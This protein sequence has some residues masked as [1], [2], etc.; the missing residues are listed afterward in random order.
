MSTN[1]SYSP[2]T[3]QPAHWGFLGTVICGA[4]ISVIFV[5]LQILTIIVAVVARK[6][7]FS[8]SEFLLIFNSAARNGYFLAIST[9]ITT[10][11]CVVL[12]AG[13]IKLKKGSVLREYLAIKP[14]P[15][16]AMLKWTGLLVSF[17]I[18][19]DLTTFFLGR[20]IVPEFM[21]AVYAT[22]NPVWMIWFALIIAAPLFEEIFFR[23]FL[24]KGFESSF[25]GLIGA[26]LVTSLF[27]S[28]I[29]IQYDA[30]G[31]TTVFFIGLI[32]GASR[33]MTGSLL[34]PLVLHAASNLIA[35]IETMALS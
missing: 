28:M 1:P 3:Q 35:T 31:I 4:V 19:S 27:W 24:F 25:M 30:Y 22:A 12:I 10:A 8:E 18:L 17:V 29:H 11:A 20:P 5:V 33:A 9:F 14:I 7:H 23:G 34:V 13:L 26:V 6:G 16:K 15:R 2:D 32:L 21:S